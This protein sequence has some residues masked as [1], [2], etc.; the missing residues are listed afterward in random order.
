MTI[1]CSQSVHSIVW[2]DFAWI[3]RLFCI[4]WNC[5]WTPKTGRAGDLSSFG[6]VLINPPFW[7]I[8][9]IGS[10]LYG[11][12]ALDSFHLLSLHKHKS[13]NT[14]Y[15]NIRRKK[16]TTKDVLG[17]DCS[18]KLKYW[19]LCEKVGLIKYYFYKKSLEKVYILLLNSIEKVC[20]HVG[21]RYTVWY[22][23]WEPSW[24][25]SPIMFFSTQMISIPQIPEISGKE[26]HTLFHA[27]IPVC[28][29][30]ILRC[31]SLIR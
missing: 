5:P 28:R 6:A 7:Y 18:E 24:L 16:G 12:V 13:T 30:F 17:K 21:R 29:Q 20:Q 10:L 9:M 1:E 15:T 22:P 3:N 25:Q 19:H 8:P 31:Q 14:L 2:I 26:L 23:A 27:P 4:F 11:N